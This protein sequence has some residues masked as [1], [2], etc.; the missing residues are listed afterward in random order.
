M[1]MH[2][3]RPLL[4]LSSLGNQRAD[5]NSHFVISQCNKNHHS[6]RRRKFN[7]LLWMLLA[8]AAAVVVYLKQKVFSRYKLCE[9]SERENNGYYVPTRSLNILYIL[10]CINNFRIPSP[11]PH[12][13]LLTLRSFFVILKNINVLSLGRI[14]KI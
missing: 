10:T 7:S 8:S 4:S 2:T 3:H 9:V 1:C 13:N 6:R 14:H 12:L 11:Q 5:E